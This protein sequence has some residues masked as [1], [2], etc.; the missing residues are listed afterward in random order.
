MNRYPVKLSEQDNGESISIYRHPQLSELHVFEVVDPIRRYRRRQNYI[1]VDLKVQTFIQTLY[2]KLYEITGFDNF[3]YIYIY[4]M[5]HRKQSLL[6]KAIENQTNY[7]DIS[8]QF[9]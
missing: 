3:P 5:V 6:G 8:I 9:D 7:R 2:R 1:R 4:T